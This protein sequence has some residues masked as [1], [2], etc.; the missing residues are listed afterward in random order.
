MFLK[1]FTDFKQQKL[2]ICKNQIAQSRFTQ[3]RRK[4]NKL[5]DEEEGKDIA[6]R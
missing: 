2:L 6:D 3:S 4:P 5:G 1:V